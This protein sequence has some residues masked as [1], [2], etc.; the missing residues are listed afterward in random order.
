MNYDRTI[1]RETITEM[2]QRIDPTWE[3]QAAT[4]ADDGHHA[5]YHLDVETATGR[6]QC[7]LKATP[8]GKEPTCD[9]E[10][11]LLAVL[12]AHTSLP[13]PEVLGVVDEHDRLP[14]PYF[15]ATTLPGASYDRTELAD[16]SP[17]A[18]ERLARS[19]GRQL[20]ALHGLDVVDAYGF[21]SVDADETL[22]GGRPDGDPGR[23]VVDDPTRSWTGY[24]ASEVDRVF[25]GLE[26]TQFGDLAP[27]VRTA[28]DARIDGLSGPFDPVVARIDQS[29]DNVLLDPETSAVTG[30]LDF[31]FAIATTPAYDLAF[32]AHS[33]AGGHWQYVPEV[34]DRRE[35]V[36]SA[37]LD[38]YRT[39]GSA[40]AVGQFRENGDCYRLLAAVHAMVNFEEW[41]DHIYDATD[42]QREGVASALRARV[43]EV[44]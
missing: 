1:P 38:G 24:L 36:R 32:V 10:A 35:T 26:A 9:D 31:E 20:A 40:R 17:T 23:I 27:A 19:T 39:V 6:R 28:L 15:L 16:F 42:A 22:D 37:L 30:L 4:P 41:F 25:P 12:D 13:V 11:R 33:L 8:P 18:V 29:L 34:P 21:V 5:V 14:T 3:V 43:T 7:V 2:V 44:V